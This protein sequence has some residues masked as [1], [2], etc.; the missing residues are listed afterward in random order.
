MKLKLPRDQM[1]LLKTELEKAG[2]KEIGGQIFGEQ[3]APSMFCGS[4]L[5]FQ[6][7]P[8]TFSRFLV[9][10]LQAAA[11]AV[12]FFD[13][14]QHNYKRYNY[15]GEW[16]SH[17]SFA[18]CPSS[19]DVQTMRNLVADKAFVGQFALLLICKL[20]GTSLEIGGWLFDPSG[21]EFAITLE[22]EHV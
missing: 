8:G 22:E 10:L 6:K 17:P 15:I 18:V 4:D 20:N 16:H 3:V 19:I 2:T 1:N 5:T 11:D 7:R 12:A 21:Q 14:T 13:R 9:D